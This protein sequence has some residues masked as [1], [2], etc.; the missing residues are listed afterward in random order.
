MFVDILAFFS[1]KFSLSI[2]D[3]IEI[4]LNYFMPIIEIEHPKVQLRYE[5]SLT[6]IN[7]KQFQD[8]RN[9]SRP[10]LSIIERK[11]NHSPNPPWDHIDNKMPH[12]QEH[13][14][15]QNFSNECINIH[16]QCQYFW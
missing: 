4:K 16:F 11:W 12:K 10:I 2:F 7:R 13:K 9:F 15:C 5:Q 8:H 14:E 3:N 1:T 6:R